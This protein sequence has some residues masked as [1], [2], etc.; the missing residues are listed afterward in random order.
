MFSA[1][2]VATWWHRKHALIT[3]YKRTCRTYFIS[4]VFISKTNMESAVE[5]IVDMGFSRSDAVVALQASNND[6]GRA[7]DYIFSGKLDERLLLQR[8]FTVTVTGPRVH[9]QTDQR[10]RALLN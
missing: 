5:Q 1:A 2:V 8:R 9:T 10:T 6:V 4:T 3:P 7:I